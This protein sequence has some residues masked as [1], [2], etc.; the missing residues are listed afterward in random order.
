MVMYKECDNLYMYSYFSFYFRYVL[1]MEGN[2]KCCIS[3]L[4]ISAPLFCQ[5]YDKTVLFL[6]ILNMYLGLL[7]SLV[8]WPTVI[9]YQFVSSSTP[10]IICLSYLKNKTLPRYCESVYIYNDVI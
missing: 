6:L 8:L 5:C 4:G 3:L 9:L 1:H 7:F 2:S 10:C